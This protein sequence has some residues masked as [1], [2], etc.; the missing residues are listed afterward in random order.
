MNYRDFEIARK[1]RKTEEAYK[2][3]MRK[4]MVRP[5]AR[6]RAKENYF[7]KNSPQMQGI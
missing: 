2:A 1:K 6:P 4:Q 3:I 5:L 7:A